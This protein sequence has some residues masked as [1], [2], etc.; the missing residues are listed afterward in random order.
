MIVRAANSGRA[1]NR[2][3]ILSE[4]PSVDGDVEPRGVAELA[5]L[6]LVV[7]KRNHLAR[8]LCPAEGLGFAQE[9]ECATSGPEIQWR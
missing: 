9:F 5:K 2:Q 3:L 7:A 8:V 1:T 6:P 4:T